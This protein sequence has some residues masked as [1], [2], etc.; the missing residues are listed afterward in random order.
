[1]NQS[2]STV[3]EPW[4]R[5]F[6]GFTFTRSELPKRRIA[7][8]AVKR[9]KERVRELGRTRGISTERMGKELA[10]CPRGWIG[11][12]GKAETPSVIQ[13]PEEWTRR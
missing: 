3:A 1:V 13:S 9:F 2:K 5:K 11:Y 10:L 12:F 7:P 8:E 4:E 6:L